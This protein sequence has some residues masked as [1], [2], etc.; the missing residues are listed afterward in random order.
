MVHNYQ[1]VE[2][3]VKEFYKEGSAPE[4]RLFAFSKRTS[5]APHSQTWKIAHWEEIFELMSKKWYV[6]ESNRNNCGL[7]EAARH[8]FGDDK[9]IRNLFY[10]TMAFD[11]TLPQLSLIIKQKDENRIFIP[12]LSVRNAIKGNFV[13]YNNLDEFFNSPSFLL[14]RDLAQY[15]ASNPDSSLNKEMQLKKFQDWT[16]AHGKKA[17]SIL[18]NSLEFHPKQKFVEGESPDTAFK[19]YIDSSLPLYE[20]ISEKITIRKSLEAT[21]E[22]S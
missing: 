21:V 13:T 6:S 8:Y 5:D 22:N 17:Y 12:N 3:D 16:Q 19:K 1:I 9:N 2:F 18:R 4:G 11:L 10:M 7:V 15:I 20:D 14:I